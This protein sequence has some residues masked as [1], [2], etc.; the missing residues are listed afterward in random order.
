MKIP[1]VDENDVQIG[2]KERDE[3][4]S[5]DFYRVAALWLTNSKGEILLAQRALSKKNSPEKWGPA[6][7]GTVE[8]GETYDSNIVKEIF[9]EIGVSVS[10]DELTKGPK[11]FVKTTEKGF[12]DQ[13]YFYTIDLPSDEFVIPEDEVTQ[14]RWVSRADFDTWYAERPEDFLSNISQWLPYLL[15]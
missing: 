8:D 10:I 11:V 7:A 2:L 4:K 6:V 1:V 9:E 12:F 3:L 14:V 5:G 15:T 13:W